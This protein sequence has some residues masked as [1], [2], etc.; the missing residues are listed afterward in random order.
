MALE[1]EA[2]R[3]EPDY[4]FRRQAHR[5]VPPLQTTVKHI[6]AACREVAQSLPGGAFAINL[7]KPD[8]FP[9]RRYSVH[10]RPTPVPERASWDENR[11]SAA[12]KKMIDKLFENPERLPNPP[13]LASRLK[14]APL[15]PDQVP[16][17]N[18]A[19]GED[20]T[21]RLFLLQHNLERS[22]VELGALDPPEPKKFYKP[23][24]TV[25]TCPP[26][27]AYL[28]PIWEPLQ[29]L[30]K[31]RPLTTQDLPRDT[32]L[33]NE[34]EGAPSFPVARIALLIKADHDKGPY[35]V[36]DEYPIG[37][38]LDPPMQIPRYAAR[39]NSLAGPKNPDAPRQ[40]SQNLARV[41]DEDP[42]WMVSPTQPSAEQVEAERLA[43]LPPKP[44]SEGVFEL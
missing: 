34:Q 8:Y 30:V 22:L 43:N 44:V 12:I 5:W 25:G 6:S 1:N 32:L 35:W 14:T 7:T 3:L 16:D 20:G 28:E 29:D 21:R 11:P 39:S 2:T 15:G 33:S 27:K 9:L 40:L 31:H 36:F 17:Y 23:H 19:Q 18:A 26:T 42:V 41:Y 13:G 37:R 38:A 10:L 24:V 4:F